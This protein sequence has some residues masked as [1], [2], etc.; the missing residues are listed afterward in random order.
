MNVAL[1]IIGRDLGA[2]FSQ[3]Q[4]AVTG[5]T[6]SLAAL[7]LLSGALGDHFGRRRVFL[8]GVAG[9]TGASVLCAAAP[10]I[11][12]LIGDRSIQGI[13]AA[14][15]TPASLAI[16]QSSFRAEDRPRAIGDLVRFRRG[17]LG[18]RAVHRRVAPRTGDV[19]VDLRD[20]RAR[21]RGA[22]P[23]RGP[24]RAGV[25]GDGRSPTF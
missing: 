21:G 17:R 10:G 6:L 11:A 1:P 5:Y 12:V 20:Q 19:A 22:R 8:I 2:D 7:I 13:G 3:L 16:V 25:P 24:S 18:H 9:F 14:L 4:W 15:M 23:H